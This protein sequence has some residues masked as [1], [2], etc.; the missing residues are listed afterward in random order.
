MEKDMETG[1][2]TKYIYAGDERIAMIDYQGRVYYYVKDHLGSTRVLV[3]D[4][5]VTSAK[6]YRY[7]AYGECKKET[8]NIAQPN[9]YTGKP[10]D[11]E[12]GLN[13]YY[14][15]AR[16]YMANL[17][18]WMSVDPRISKYR[19]LSPYNYCGSNP[20]QRID[21]NGEEWYTSEVVGFRRE[22]L[23]QDLVNS[24]SLEPGQKEIISDAL[25][26]EFGSEIGIAEYQYKVNWATPSHQATKTLPFIGPIYAVLSEGENFA[27]D[28]LM[29]LIIDVLAYGSSEKIIKLIGFI[30]LAYSGYSAIE[31][32]DDPRLIKIFEKMFGKN[33]GFS[34]LEEAKEAVKSAKKELER[35]RAE[36]ERLRR[37]VEEQ[38]KSYV[39]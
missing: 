9:K 1:Q 15:G 24:S 28:A 20:I 18:R 23:T 35:Q 10:L 21:V 16:Y 22:V 5:G 17:G 33:P 11:G 14:F 2:V 26:S 12:L 27:A 30:Y 39:K 38:S 37:L 36:E 6:Y 29:S 34:S 31:G 13:L 8:M 4:D 19:S 3:R 25:V 32:L 7:T